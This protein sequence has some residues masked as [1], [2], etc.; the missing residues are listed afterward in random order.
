MKI[1]SFIDAEVEPRHGRVLDIGCFRSDG[2]EY[3]GRSI[4][5]FANFLN[6]TDYLCGH[7]IIKH[8]LKYLESIFPAISMM[9]DRTI[10][11]LYWSPLLFPRRPYHALLKD[12][13]LQTDE[14]NNPLNDAK[15]ACDLF[16]DE[17]T[18]FLKLDESLKEI[19]FNLLGPVPEFKAF[20]KIMDYSGVR[21][22]NGNFISKLFQPSKPVKE[23][24]RQIK[25]YL[26]GKICTN[27]NLEKY[28][29]PEPVALSYA[30]SIIDTMA[31]DNMERSL[32]PSWVLRN[33]P[34]V[35]QIVFKLTSPPSV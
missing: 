12:D 33:F 29:L 26:D 17:V 30:I 24:E 31:A 21:K 16:N 20:F 22:L 35:E 3:H 23:I 9:K 13:K 2:R 15:K 10:D 8:D 1:I 7:N 5:N 25:E 19:Y 11:T 4:Q 34:M 27:V 32:T 18:A 14:L 6:G 28:I